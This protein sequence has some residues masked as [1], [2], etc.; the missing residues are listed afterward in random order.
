MRRLRILALRLRSLLRWRR[1]EQELDD[2][3]R[4]HVDRQVAA[5]IASGET[6]EGARRLAL[7]DMGGLEQRREECRDTRGL[8]LIEATGAIARDAFRSLRRRPVTVLVTIATLAIGISGSATTLAVVGSVVWRSPAGVSEPQRLVRVPAGT[9]VAFRKLRDASRLLDTA[10]HVHALRT[11]GSGSSAAPIALECVTPRYFDVLGTRTY[12]GRAFTDAD[13][14]LDTNLTIVLA[15]AFWRRQFHADPAALG[16]TLQIARRTYTVVGVAPPDFQGAGVQPVEAWI[17]VEASPAVCSFTGAN[18]LHVD[19]GAWLSTIGRLRPGA[20]EQEAASEAAAILSDEGAAR[21]QSSPFELQPLASSDRL[22]VRQDRRAAWWLFG[23]GAAILLIACANAG[24]VLAI[25]AIDRYRELAIRTQLGATRARIAA[26]ASAEA[27]SIGLIAGVAAIL[28]AIGLARL[29]D[30]FFAFAPDSGLLDWRFFA[31]LAAITVAAGFLCSIVPTLHALRAPARVGVAAGHSRG[32]VRLRTT[33][34][35]AQVAA[36]VILATVAGLFVRSV[37]NLR[38]GLG[39]ETS[40]VVSAQVDF[41]KAGYRRQ[42]PIRAFFER[43]VERA[44]ATPGVSRVALSHNAPL[45]SASISVSSLRSATVG[46]KSGDSLNDIVNVVSA[47]YFTTLGTRVLQGRDFAEADNESHEPVVIV[48][49]GLARRLWP[50]GNALG[51]CAFQF[52]GGPC[53]RVVGVVESRRHR[54]LTNVN[55]E[56]FVPIAQTSAGGELSPRAIL[57]RVDDAS[58]AMVASIAAS[59]RSASTDMPYVDVR[60]LDD[61]VDREA[62]SWRLGATMFSTF[63]V[64]A[65]LLSAIGLFTALSFAIRQRSRE[66]GVRLALGAPFAHVTWVVTRYALVVVSI[67]L[68]AGGAGVLASGRVIQASLFGV[69]PTDARVY[70]TAALAILLAAAAACILPC[71]RARRI[72]PI[73]VLR[74]E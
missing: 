71:V 21:R 67:G 74:T 5:L 48:D 38:T 37:T 10:A 41:E 40:H 49:A 73:V 72:D 9:H 13:A 46:P 17:V 4:Y 12:L 54:S 2:E 30:G 58:D 27:F 20:S 45:T 15:H 52:P 11:F 35:V 1:V 56:Y 53:L 64:A 6:P 31:G 70:L 28:L 44:H 57:I 36:A 3:L 23:G 63:G 25:R 61:V 43:L 65:A 55:P 47:G 69:A 33:L 60:R 19:S 26:H 8:H 68:V 42:T 16:R 66:I 51:S 39:Y 18:L 34:L 59:L 14:A 50:D 32:L 7:Q 22:Q 29:F 62:R 24:G